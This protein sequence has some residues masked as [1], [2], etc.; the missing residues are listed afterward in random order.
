MD[1]R[2]RA[3]ARVPVHDIEFEMEPGVKTVL[4]PPDGKREGL[5][6]TPLDGDR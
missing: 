4:D 6:E 1:Q 2:H 5:G 3:V